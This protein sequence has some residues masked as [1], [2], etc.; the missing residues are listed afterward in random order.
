MES[1]EKKLIKLRE[2]TQSLAESCRDIGEEKTHQLLLEVEEML[3]VAHQT[4]VG[5]ALKTTNESSYSK[6]RKH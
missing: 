2:D 3:E 1:I 6:H 5:S 4:F